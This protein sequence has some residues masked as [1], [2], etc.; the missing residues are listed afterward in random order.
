MFLSASEIQ[1]LVISG[2]LLIDPFL[3]ENFKPASYILRLGNRWR[4]WFVSSE[5]IDMEKSVDTEKCFSPI[6]TSNEYVL[7]NT[8]FCLAA[9]IEKLSL[10]PNLVGIVVPLS[11]ILRC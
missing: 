3:P 8:E 9:T 10:P 4:K 7:S 6:I 5:P 1:D 2:E 11:H